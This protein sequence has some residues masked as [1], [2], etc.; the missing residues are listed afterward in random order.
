MRRGPMARTR[1]LAC[2]LTARRPGGNR[3]EAG[4]NREEAG[5][6]REEAGGNREATGNRRAG[7]EV[8]KR[9]TDRLAAR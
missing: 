9:L 2:N 6:N 3:E 4:G 7:V 1:A 5:G 8:F